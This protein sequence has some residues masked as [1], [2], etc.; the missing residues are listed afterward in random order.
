MKKNHERDDK[1]TCVVSGTV[2]K[3]K[4]KKEKGIVRFWR[5]GLAFFPKTENVFRRFRTKTGNV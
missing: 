2:Q 1:R 4:K 3:G 5:N